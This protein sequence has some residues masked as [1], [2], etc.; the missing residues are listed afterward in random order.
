MYIFSPWTCCW[1]TAEG[2]FICFQLFYT[3]RFVYYTVSIITTNVNRI[4]YR[5]KAL[6]VTLH[7]TMPFFRLSSFK[8][9]DKI[10]FLSPSNNH[11]C[12][13]YVIFLCKCILCICLSFTIDINSSICNIFTCLP[14]GW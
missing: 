7:W 12:I 11:K 3:N 10:S 5:K 4:F 2:F 14:F 8:C 6:S 9:Y 13:F 1:S